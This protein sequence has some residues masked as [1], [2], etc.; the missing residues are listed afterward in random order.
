MKKYK[1]VEITWL[2]SLHRAGW[3]DKEEIEVTSLEG[4]THKTIGYFFAEDK[5]SILVIQS[6]NTDQA[7]GIMEIP[8]KAILKVKLPKQG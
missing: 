5:K 7:D 6:Y 3:L 2:D 4:M 8:K 1:I